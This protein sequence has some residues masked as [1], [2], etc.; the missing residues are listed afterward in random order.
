[1]L[2]TF[3]QN[4]RKNRGMTQEYVASQLEI[5]RPTYVQVEAGGRDLTV[6]EAARLAE[7]FGI[8]LDS[9]LAER[10]EP[11]PKVEL[12]ATPEKADDVLS[13]DVVIRVA[14]ENKEKFKQVLLYVLEKVGA[15]PN[16]GEAV[17]YKLLYFIDFDYYEKYEE[18]LI[19]ATYIR[20][21]HGP[22]PYEF[23]EIV[24]EMNRR[25]ELAEIKNKYF[26]YPQKKY[27]P[28]VE[29]DLTVLTG[30]E[31]DHID[32]VLARLAD[33]NATDI[34]AYSH[35]DIPWKVAKPGEKLEYESVFYRDEKYSVRSQDDEL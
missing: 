5:S 20:N 4:L 2:S 10:D 33:K 15:R 24:S 14:K 30:R 19:G 32:D 28:V 26:N 1:M 25:H 3:V 29:P 13:G 11:S 23:K 8:S 16:V 6:P 18:T 12:E 27:L 34:S 7:I 31:L 22:T 21:R 35:G 9:L 17:L